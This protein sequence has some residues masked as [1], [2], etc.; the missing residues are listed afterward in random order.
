MNV[1]D[2]LLQLPQFDTNISRMLTYSQ[3]FT[4]LVIRFTVIEMSL[5]HLGFVKA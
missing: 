5:D 2:S 4:T 3:D 1:V